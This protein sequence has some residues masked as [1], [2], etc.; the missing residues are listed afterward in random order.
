[1]PI[2]FG[3]GGQAKKVPNLY[4]GVGGAAKKVKAGWIGIGG[5]AKLFYAGI[6]DVIA[7]MTR[8]YRAYAYWN[9][10]KHEWHYGTEYGMSS[11]YAAI[12]GNTLTVNA[13]Y[14]G[15]ND[16]YGF[17]A[18]VS[19]DKVN[20]TGKKKI[21]V[22][23]RVDAVSPTMGGYTSNHADVNL[24]YGANL[25]STGYNQSIYKGYTKIGAGDRITRKQV[26]T[27]V[28]NTFD[29]NISGSYYLMVFLEG[30]PCSVSGDNPSL[31]GKVTITSIE[32]T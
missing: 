8:G 9:G 24:Y 25:P 12:S 4:I 5:A 1:M 10:N 29:I 11:S 32:L 30:Y 21:T 2:F 7:N 28:T 13:R 17:A 27:I 3:V 26:G 20:L 23:Y 31:A 15:T 22:K 6:M 19:T 14:N 16:Y 18:K